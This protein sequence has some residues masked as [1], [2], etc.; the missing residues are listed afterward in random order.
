MNFLKTFWKP[1]YTTFVIVLKSGYSFEVKSK[2]LTIKW[3]TNTIEI[4][5]YDFSG[6]KTKNNNYPFHIVLSEIAAIIKKV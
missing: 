4:N 1:R 3:S 5:S 6:I 2:D